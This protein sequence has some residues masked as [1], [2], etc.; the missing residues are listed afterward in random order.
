MFRAK[1]FL[2]KSFG[3]PQGLMSFLRAYN[4]A[5]PELAA[6]QKWFTRGSVP[7]AWLPVLLAY[8]EVDRGGPVSLISFIEGTT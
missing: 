6:V 1:E 7:A 2:I 8:L 3:N 5:A 4:V